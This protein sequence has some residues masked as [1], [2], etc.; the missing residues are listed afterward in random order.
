MTSKLSW[1]LLLW[2][3]L[4]LSATQAQVIVVN[5]SV[6]LAEISKAEV[7]DIFTGVA[8]NF[9]DGSRAVPATLKS[10][11]AQDGF[12]KNY[13]SRSDAAFRAT[14]REIVFAGQGVMPKAFP[15]SAALVEYVA[16]VP[17]AI[18][19]V[20]SGTNTSSVKVLEVK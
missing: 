10:G 5:R 13:L 1:L 3:W 11:P 6:K 12:L 15:T 19:Y 17:G 4:G 18:G 20:D 14:W 16:S 2:S 9:K 8:S 7:R